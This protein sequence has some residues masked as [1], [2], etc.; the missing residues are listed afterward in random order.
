MN[1]LQTMTY[2]LSTIS[3]TGPYLQDRIKILLTRKMVCMYIRCLIIYS[4]SV[5]TVT[6]HSVFGICFIIF[7]VSFASIYIHA[8]QASYSSVQ[9][10]PRRVATNS[11]L[12]HLV[13]RR[14]VVLLVSRYNL[15]GSELLLHVGVG[16]FGVC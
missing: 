16:L 1:T 4:T 12:N 5:F 9:D 6:K 2:G 11:M 10:G 7:P 14:V 3:Y 8:L 13:Y 15:H